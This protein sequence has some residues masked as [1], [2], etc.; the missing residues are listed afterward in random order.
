MRDYKH[1]KIDA[2]GV[3]RAT[4]TLF[5][6]KPE[7]L[8]G[9]NDFPPPEYKIDHYNRRRMRMEPPIRPSDRMNDRMIPS[10]ER[11]M[12]RHERINERPVP[13]ERMIQREVPKMPEKHVPVN[14]QS[15]VL[16]DCQQA[17]EQTL[18]LNFI[19]KV[20]AKLNNM[21][22]Y[23]NFIESLTSYQKTKDE[24]ILGKIKRI[25]GESK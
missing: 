13:Q 19:K 25:L 11:I 4:S 15:N 17:E 20:K 7:I 14:N 21:K 23:K 3:V 8:G 6:G 2:S 1:S 12:E 5:K 18:A 24:M 16:W 10:H 22:L 9:F